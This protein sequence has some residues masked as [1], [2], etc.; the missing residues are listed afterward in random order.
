MLVFLFVKRGS[1]CGKASGWTVDGSRRED[2]GWEEGDWNGGKWDGWEVLSE[3]G[4]D[5]KISE[6]GAS[7]MYPHE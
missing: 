3:Q 6:P 5:E 1:G 7:H 4:L 2:G